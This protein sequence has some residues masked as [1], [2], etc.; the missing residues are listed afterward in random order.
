[1]NNGRIVFLFA[2]TLGL[3]APDLGA[4]QPR[5][6]DFR[7]SARAAERP[8]FPDVATAADGSFVVVWTELGVEDEQPDSVKAR[9]FD[10]AGRPRSGPILVA[11]TVYTLGTPAV[12]MAPDGRFV[13]VWQ[14]AVES[15]Y[16]VFGR[17]YDAAGR[18]LGPRFRLADTELDQFEPDVAM[19]SDGSFVNVWYQPDGSVIAGI[20]MTDV[21]FRLFAADGRPRDRARVAIGGD[22]TQN[23]P[24]VAL[25]PD[26]GFVVV[27]Q[28]LMGERP[29]EIKAQLFSASGG[30]LGS[31]FLVN[32]D[33]L[34]Y[35]RVEPAVAVA[36]DGRFAIAW[37]DRGGDFARD[38][39]DGVGVAARFYAADATPLGPSLRPNTFL[40]GPQEKPAVSALPNRGFL[41]LWDSG[42]DLDRSGRGI[43]ARVFGPHGMPRG[44]EQLVISEGRLGPPAVSVAPNGRGIAV[45]SRSTDDERTAIIGRLLGPQRK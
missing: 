25:R 3:A 23:I 17:R 7:I 32:D 31:A 33:S 27:C 41:V 12:A 45:W 22:E 28:A 14:G 10:A 43:F 8:A 29:Y 4:Q 20:T 35:D 44:D 13:V 40:P 6:S 11:R 34:P 30:P 16:L 26:G 42:G 2:L 37:T 21:V 5:G 19:A 9:L 36:A 15:P 18:P 24:Q 39:E 1:M 38:H